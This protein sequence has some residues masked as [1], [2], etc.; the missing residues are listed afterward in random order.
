MNM[1]GMRACPLL[2]LTCCLW[3]TY[4]SPGCVSAWHKRPWAA[5]PGEEAL[6]IC[7]WT[8]IWA[9]NRDLLLWLSGDSAE[10]MGSICM[11][12]TIC[13]LH[14]SSFE[15]LCWVRLHKQ[16]CH[17]LLYARVIFGEW[18]FISQCCDLWIFR[19]CSIWIYLK[20]ILLLNTIVEMEISN[21]A[22]F[23]SDLI[24]FGSSYPW[25]QLA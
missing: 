23:P 11:F 17:K 21:V 20:K 5:L 19:S 14:H 22:Q 7:D 16:T 3:E 10:K 13:M 15:G 6:F 4:G 1:R 24:L 25:Q 9:W 2:L 12:Y 8:F 18:D